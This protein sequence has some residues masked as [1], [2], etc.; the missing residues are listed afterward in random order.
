MKYLKFQII[1]KK[2]KPVEY[3]YNNKAGITIFIGSLYLVSEVR[4]IILKK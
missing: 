2:L 1:V 4:N 3:V